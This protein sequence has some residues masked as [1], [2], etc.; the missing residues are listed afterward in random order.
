MEKKN[1]P[2]YGVL[3]ISR[4]AIGGK[5]TALFGSSIMHNNVI[6]LSICHAT[7]EREGNEDRYFAKGGMKDRIIEVEMSYTQFAEAI[8]SLNIGEGVP[9]T[10]TNIGGQFLPECPYEDR[11]GVM[12]AEV[13]EITADVL[14]DLE[15]GSA[16]IENLLSE[17]RVLS[18]EDRSRILDTLKHARHV[19]DTNIPYLQEMFTEQMNKTVTEAKGELES[20]LQNKMNSIALAVISENTKR[21]EV[22]LNKNMIPGLEDHENSEEA[23]NQNE[24]E[25]KEGMQIKL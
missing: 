3:R 1:H 19:L 25:M 17:K 11:H 23:Q 18:R 12:A 20:Y 7:M 22:M 4:T 9:V 8:T 15:S 21:E 24:E 13:R 2:S 16:E 6:R 14:R 10:I 5:G